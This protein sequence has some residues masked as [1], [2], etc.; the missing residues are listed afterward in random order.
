MQP[1]RR[2]RLALLVLAALAVLLV[3]G[4]VTTSRAATLGAVRWPTTPVVTTTTMAGTA[5]TAE[6]TLRWPTTPSIVHH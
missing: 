1:T 2:V 3:V 5:P 6:A 4:V